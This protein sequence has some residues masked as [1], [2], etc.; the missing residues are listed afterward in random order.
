M[1]L[2]DTLPGGDTGSIVTEIGVCSWSDA[3]SAGTSNG[4]LPSA[5]YTDR[6][7]NPRWVCGRKKHK[8]LFPAAHPAAI[9]LKISAPSGDS[10]FL[11]FAIIQLLIIIKK[12]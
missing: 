11:Y 6:F 1:I 9:S 8:T 5:G 12:Y 2:S 7:D 3:P 10:N 4:F